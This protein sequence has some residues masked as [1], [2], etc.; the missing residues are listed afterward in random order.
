MKSAALAFALGV[1]LLQT[2]AQLPD[3]LL[4]S[5]PALLLCLPAWRWRRWPARLLLVIG[6]CGL[7]FGWAAWRAELRLADQLGA[8]W[9]GRDV[10]V[11]GVVAG[12]PQDFE[13]GVRF[14]FAIER[15]LDAG[16]VVPERV[17]LAWYDDGE[18]KHPV[19]PGERWQF[20]VRLKRPHGAANPGGFDYE[21]WLLE[22]GIRATGY[23]RPAPAQRL[24][25][26]VAR[27]AYLVERLRAAVRQRFESA[28]PAA[29]HPWR[30]ILTALAVG[31]QKAVDG[32][33]W[34][35]FNRS[36]VT[37]AMAISG[38]HITLVAGF[39][40]A[41]LAGLWRRLPGLALRWPAQKVGLLTA[42]MTAV[43]YTALAGFG[44]PA[45][46]TLYMLLVAVAAM[47]S[48][49][50][51]APG[52]VLALALV[53][54]LVIDPWAVLAPGFWLSFGVVAALLH[55]GA[56]L[57]GA[58]RGW[59]E[60]LRGWGTVQ[61]A[62][63]LASLPILLLVFGQFPLISP[64]AN[65]VA[66]PVISLLVTPLA[67]LAAVLPWDFLLQAAH[68]VLEPLMQFLIWCAGWPLWQVPAPHPAAVLLAA[69]GVVVCLLPRGVPGR[70]LGLALLLPLLF[71]PAP[72][73]PDGEARVEV[74]D[75][76]QGLA[77]TVRTRQHL[78]VYD[79]GPRYG[80]DADAGQRVLVPYL[81]WLGATRIDRL[82]VTHGD[83]DH[84]G[85]AESLR[86]ALAVDDGISSDA[87]QGRPCVAGE[88]WRWDGVDFAVLHPAAEAYAER[89]RHNALSCVLALT[90][91][92][93]RLLLT[94][95]IAAREEAA[96]LA[97]DAP[98]LRSTVLLAPHHGAKGSSTAEFLAAVGAQEVLFSVGHRNRFGHP[99]P[100]VL[101]RYAASGARLWRTDRDGALLLTLRP[102]GR[103]IAAWRQRH[104][105]YW[106]GR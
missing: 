43:A 60:R 64:L 12:L 16:A 106:R 44:V 51:V 76:G 2:Q 62:A 102:A 14:E 33:L 59:R 53:V 6:A 17:Q 72:E 18:T 90:V 61:L 92:G 99:R 49:R 47:F 54:V 70:W 84:A 103:E 81:R 69:I 40:G 46:R 78:L 24:D 21:L 77:V 57:V 75:V 20:T 7:G 30:G 55:V 22:R 48:G 31:D 45:Q 82:L 63:T 38:M 98:A 28:L 74:L 94:A 105:R 41:L 88:T 85:G 67:L 79:T 3:P 73:I 96:L 34:T 10:A 42:A 71:W 32:D 13:R 9:E 1:F 97:R 91:G 29:S 58:G 95:D 26:F 65:L 19:S 36:G 27:P 39:C 87:A 50:I 104:Q 56:A 52:R 89:G 5:L 101:E 15:R 100:E 11:V 66:I 68:A 86:A 4:W 83:A 93:E 23:V 35:I 8:L 25:A 80:N 37:H